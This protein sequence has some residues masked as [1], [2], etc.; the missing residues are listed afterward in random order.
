MSQPLPMD[1]FRWLEKHEIDQL[2]VK[3]I[4]LGVNDE[5]G[6]ILEVDLFITMYSRRSMEI[7]LTCLSQIL[8]V[9]V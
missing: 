3:I 4:E 8:T 5:K 9:C 6:Y 1:G 2:F 7:E